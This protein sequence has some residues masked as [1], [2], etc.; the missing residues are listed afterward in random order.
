[1]LNHRA[2]QQS[3]K[4]NA[5]Q[6]LVSLQLLAALTCGSAA[7]AGILSDALNLIDPNKA[8]L[9]VAPLRALAIKNGHRAPILSA[10][11]KEII[12]RL[13]FKIALKNSEVNEIN[14]KP[15]ITDKDVKELAQRYFRLAECYENFRDYEN[16]KFNELYGIKLMKQ[17]PDC[18][19]ET[20]NHIYSL[21]LLADAN[22]EEADAERFYKQAIAFPIER[23]TWSFYRASRFYEL[24]GT[25]F[26]PSHHLAELYIRQGRFWDAEWQCR[27]VEQD[28][29]GRNKIFAGIKFR[30]AEEFYDVTS[31]MTRSIFSKQNYL[32]TAAL[33]TILY[34]L[35]YKSARSI[36]ERKELAE[37]IPAAGL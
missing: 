22:N 26:W 29:Y 37:F 10:K 32:C 12:R 18:E 27:D 1:M 16:A 3:S 11:S 28:F 8:E 30:S 23:E 31:D 6:V 21:A 14:G 7:N 35:G 15:V 24:D 2:H 34:S 33:A 20:E 19:R 4:P 9:A 17:T 25:C 36:W 5:K 13:R